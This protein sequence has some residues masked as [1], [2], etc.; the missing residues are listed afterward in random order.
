[1]G[2]DTET[3]T[4]G[5]VAHRFQASGI[6]WPLRQRQWRVEILRQKDVL[7]DNTETFISRVSG[8]GVLC[9]A[10]RLFGHRVSDTSK[11]RVNYRSKTYWKTTRKY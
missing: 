9:Q 3:S 1:M 11:S 8:S 10:S 4:I 5:S 7:E 6:F 2:K